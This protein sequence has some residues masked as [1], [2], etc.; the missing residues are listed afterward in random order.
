LSGVSEIINNLVSGEWSPARGGLSCHFDVASWINFIS[1]GALEIGR[2][3]CIGSMWYRSQQPFLMV[4]DLFTVPVWRAILC[5]LQRTSAFSFD[6][7]VMAGTFFLFMKTFLRSCLDPLEIGLHR[8]CVGA[9][10]DYCI[11][12]YR[13]KLDAHGR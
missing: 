10:R 2:G 7:F 3:S 1:G 8:V 12:V 11:R 4:T 6:A 5:G 9:F 13:H